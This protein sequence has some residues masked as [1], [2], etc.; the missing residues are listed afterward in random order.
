[1]PVATGPVE[2]PSS[3]WRYQLTFYGWLTGLNGHVGVRGL[4]PANVDISAKDA[5]E[6]LDGALMG[7]FLAQNDKWTLLFDLIYTD[8]TSQATF[9]PLGGS[10]ARLG[11]TQVIVQG[12]AGYALPVGLPEGA[13]LSGTVGFRYQHLDSDFNFTNAYVPLAISSSGTQDWIDPTVGLF[14]QYKINDKWFFNAL[15]DVGGFGVSSK[16]TAQGFASLGY[17]WTDSLST[18]IGYRAIYTDYEDGGFV[19]DVTQHG[20][21]ISAAYHF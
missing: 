11:L 12:L 7:S 3:D 6:D 16:L 1:M 10:T 18:A 13:T 4:P 2:I 15:G 5:L 21:F 20:V 17:M 8:V 14:L 9:G 19:Y